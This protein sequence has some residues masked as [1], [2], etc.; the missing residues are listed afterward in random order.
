MKNSFNLR[1][2][3]SESPKQPYEWTDSTNLVHQKVERISSEILK[4]VLLTGGKIVDRTGTILL[5]DTKNAIALRLSNSGE[6]KGRSFLEYEKS[7][8]V[9]EYASNLKISHIE[10][11]GN[12]KKVEYSHDLAIEK[13]MKDYIIHSIKEIKNEYLGK[14]LYF[15]CGGEVESYSRDKLLKYVESA[16][17]D[18][19]LKLYNFLIES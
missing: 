7:L 19:N 8:D 14:Y 6:I 13:E 11:V 3:F 12:G 10:F 15:L 4:S 18:K 5:S 2:S 17:I 16:S 1:V 9:C